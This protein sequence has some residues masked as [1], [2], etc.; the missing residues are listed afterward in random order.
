MYGYVMAGKSNDDGFG[1]VVLFVGFLGMVALGLGIRAIE[2][3]GQ[4]IVVTVI[5]ASL[6]GGV[7]Y[8]NR[9]LDARWAGQERREREAAELVER[10]WLQHYDYLDGN[11]DGIYGEHKPH[12]L[13]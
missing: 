13:D 12:A 6:L 10:A 11:A 4:N 9:R 8:A 1:A 5:L 2:W 3:A 7:W